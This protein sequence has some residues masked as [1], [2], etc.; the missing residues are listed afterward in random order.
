MD[1]PGLICDAL[2]PLYGAAAPARTAEM[3]ATITGAPYEPG[4]ER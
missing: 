1:Y 3:I 4:E 2:R